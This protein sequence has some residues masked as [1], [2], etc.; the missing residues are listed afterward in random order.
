MAARADS[1]RVKILA[2][3]VGYIIQGTI[4][5]GLG[6]WSR[7]ARIR[8][9]LGLSDLPRSVPEA[10]WDALSGEV[11]V[12]STPARVPVDSTDAD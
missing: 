5:I 2:G 6:S 3:R 11:V 10:D 12:V 4:G 9:Q 1:T 7:A 8:D